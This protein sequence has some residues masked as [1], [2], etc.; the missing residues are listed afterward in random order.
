M[1]RA[2]WDSAVVNMERAVALHP[3][4]VYHRLEL[5]GVYLDVAQPVKAIDQLQAIES[6]PIGDPMDPYY[7]RLAAAA[8]A[9]LRNNK[10]GDAKERLRKS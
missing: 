3:Q 5:A 7:K 10:A 4:L 8:L 2:S 9:D 6:L 1:D